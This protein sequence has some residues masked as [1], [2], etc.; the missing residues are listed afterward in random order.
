ML[1]NLPQ[2]TQVLDHSVLDN[3]DSVTLQIHDTKI[4]VTTQRNANGTTTWFISNLI[5][6]FTTSQA[7]VEDMLAKFHRQHDWVQDPK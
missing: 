6:W 7:H 4:T 2:D 1:L 3:G 5:H